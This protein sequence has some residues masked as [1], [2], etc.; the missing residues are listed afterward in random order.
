MRTIGFRSNILF[1]IAAAFGVVAALGR[2]WYGPPRAAT[3]AEMEDLLGG[4]GRAF[5]EPGGTTGWEALRTADELIAGLAV[6]T[7][8]LLALTLVPALQVH[9]QPVARW[10][11]LATLGVVLLKLVDGPGTRAMSEPRHGLFIALGAAVVL[12]ASTA[13]VA[14]APSRRRMHVKTYTPPPA[15]VYDADATYGPPQF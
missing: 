7:V 10:A 4:I 6:G 9:L 13:T 8:A 14:A 5:S 2:P 15:P 3:D 1:A 12:L 11:A